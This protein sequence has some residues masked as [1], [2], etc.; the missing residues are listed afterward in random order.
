M[1]ALKFVDY[2][3]MVAYM[4]RPTESDDFTEIVDFLNATPIWYALNVN[5]TIYVSC[6]EQFWSIAKAQTINEET[7]IYV[8][9]DGK[10]IVITESSVR[11]DLQFID[12]DGTDCL[13]ITI[14]F[15][16]LKLMGY[17][18]LSNKLTF[19]K[20]YFSHKWK[21]LVHII[22]QCLSPKKNAWNEFSSNI[23]SAI[24][25]LATNQ[26]F[27]FSKMV[28][29]G[30]TRNLDSLSAKF[31]MYPRI[32]KDFSRKVTPLFDTMLIQHQSEVGD[33]L[34]KAAT[35][36]SS[37]EAEHVSG[38]ITKTR[39]KA[40]LNEPTPQG[41]GS[42]SGPR[43][44]DTKGDTIARTRFE[45]VS[46]TSYDSPL[47]GVNT[48]RSD[49]DIMKLK[50]LME[51]YTNLLQRVQDLKTTKTAQ[52][53]EITSQKRG[54]RSYNK[55]EGDQEDASKHGRNIVEIDADVDISLVHEDAGIE[56]RFDDDDMFDT[57]VFN[58]KEVFA[59][60]DMADPEVNV[61]EKEVSVADPVTTAGEVVTTASVDISTAS[62]P[63]TIS[64]ATP[65]TP[66][67]TTTEDDM[68]LV[69]TLMEIRS[70]KPKAIGVVMQEPSEIPRISVAQQQIQENAQG[71]RDKGKAKMVKE[72]EPKE[73][74]KRKYQ[75]NHDE[76]LAKRL[77]AQLQ[78]EMEEE[79][80]LARQR[81]EEDNIVS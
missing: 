9:V 50:E 1:A 80:R 37:L 72:E 81:E 48:P 32:G 5:P 41:T 35:T 77:K 47:G 38:N 13:P 39:S 68:T 56:G 73:P 10:K 36:A 31:L 18:N 21:F 7:Q 57:S 70:A 29:D 43:R 71:L 34:D 2:H 22:L 12:E 59:R 6:I 46:K 15:K 69:E 61:A 24:I 30:M 58:D 40:T 62:V 4:E 51:M 27:N 54:S 76:E 66:P 64:T 26:K 74:T 55:E 17:E 23:A 78:A 42:C 28:F 63:I 52:A 44:Q 16:N 75:I 49:E 3:N 14:I 45:N 79:D 65:T 19:L 25:C 20:S 8:L 67:T 11:R 33:S 53:K 60:Q